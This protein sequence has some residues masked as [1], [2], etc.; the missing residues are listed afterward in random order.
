MNCTCGAKSV[1]AH[2]HSAWCDVIE[3][4]HR[5]AFNQIRALAN[6]R[7]GKSYLYIVPGYKPHS[8]TFDRILRTEGDNIFYKVEGRVMSYADFRTGSRIIVS[9]VDSLDEC[10][11]G[12]IDG[13]FLE[14]C[15]D[16]AKMKSIAA[17]WMHEDGFTR[18]VDPDTQ[19]VIHGVF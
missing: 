12:P 17:Y 14:Q 8:Y 16:I 5:N 6:S 13:A 11:V 3:Q 4:G 19:E 7:Q 9:S 10:V 2:L 15:D 18:I 1:G